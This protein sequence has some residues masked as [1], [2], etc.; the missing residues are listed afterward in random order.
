M[1]ALT[2]TASQ[3]LRVSGDVVTGT[4]GATITA[5]QSVYLSSSNTWLLA[6]ADGTAAESGY[7]SEYG[8]ALHA[9][10][11]GQ[12]IDVQINGD[13]TLGAGAAPAA[14]IPYFVGTT[15]GD[16]VL[17][18]DLSAGHY[19]ALLGIG[20]GTNKVRITRCATGVVKA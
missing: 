16:I 5:G 19:T 14:G 7:G 12:P 4:A 11:S 18:G 2:I 1:A 8:I 10:L 6:Q 3:V 9:S 15:A 17:S 13:I 20:M